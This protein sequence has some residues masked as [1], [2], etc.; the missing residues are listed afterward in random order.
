MDAP[1]RFGWYIPTHGDGRT[2]ADPATFIPPDMDLFMRVAHAAEDAGFEYALVPVAPGCYEAWISTAMMSAKTER[3]TM[4]VAARPGLIAPTVTAK[5]VSTFDHLS[6]GR[7][8]VNLIA[9]GGIEEMA[10]DGVFLG[11]DE[12]YEVIDETVTLMKRVWAED[13]PV[14]FEGKHFRVEKAVVRPR[15]LQQPHPPFYIGGISPAAQDVG[16]KHADVY[17]FWGNTPEQIRQDRAAVHSRAA[18]YGRTDSL[19]YGMR[20][21]VLVRETEEQAWRDADAL[22]A[23]ASERM[24]Q[25]R[26]TG[27]G[28]ESHADGRMRA[29]A[30]ETAADNY[31]IAPNL[32]AGLT[33]VRHGAGVMMVG[34]PA[35]VAATIQEFIDAGCS[36]FCL[37]GYPHD[38][39]AERFGRLV[40]PY[41]RHAMAR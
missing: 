36:E 38:E 19:R 8:S 5:M 6:G 15:P 12:R 10:A 28:Q 14:N 2:V 21:Q 26:M 32:W 39:E 4:L 22:I 18:A 11:H 20:L 3:L 41:F 7:V 13:E 23:T 29:L 37:S 9:G 34:N 17:L 30:I 16:A 35:Q 31:R 1:L 24:R 25:V 27:M 40:M 33:T